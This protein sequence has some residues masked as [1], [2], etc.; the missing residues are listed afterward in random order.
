MYGIETGF[1]PM[2]GLATAGLLYAAYYGLVRLKCTAVWAQLF[3]ATSVVLT[4]VLTLA[5]PVTMVEAQPEM[6]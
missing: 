3:I 1:F 4:T 6:T 5:S 2:A